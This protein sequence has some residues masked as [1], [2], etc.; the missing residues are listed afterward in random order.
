MT[1]SVAAAHALAGAAIVAALATLGSGCLL[2]GG[3]HSARPIAEGQ[4]VLGATISLTAY[5]YVNDNGSLEQVRLVSPV[6][7]VS[8]RRGVG[9]NV[10][11]GGFLAVGQLAVGADVKV[12]FL[13]RGAVHLAVAPALAIQSLQ[14]MSGAR[15]RVPLVASVE[16]SDRL[17]VNGA[18]S[19]LGSLYTTLDPNDA[20]SDLG[21]FQGA[22]VAVAGALGIDI[23][24][25]RLQIRPGLELTRTLVGSRDAGFEPFTAVNGFVYLGYSL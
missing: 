24:A 5:D 17:T 12:R 13:H 11:V 1:D 3:G 8:L 18:L 15:A 4:S 6:P 7:E 9:E 23:A 16:L 20:G 10:D 19:V 22:Q 25:G 21:V 2:A 14:V